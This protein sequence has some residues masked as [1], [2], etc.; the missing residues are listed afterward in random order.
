MF[1]S[2]LALPAAPWPASGP[3][4]TGRAPTLLKVLDRTGVGAA[5]VVDRLSALTDPD[6]G[7]RP[8]TDLAMASLT[9]AAGSRLSRPWPGWGERHLPPAPRARDRAHECRDR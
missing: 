7:R 1:S 4:V 6:P 2:L 8:S 9:R 3:L 5:Q